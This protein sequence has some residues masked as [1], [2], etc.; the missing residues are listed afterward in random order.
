FYVGVALFILLSTPRPYLILTLAFGFACFGRILAFVF[1][2]VRS[3]QHVG[4][5]IGDAI[6]S[7]IPLI[8]VVGGFFFVE[9]I[10]GW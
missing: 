9:Q 1:D 2:R 5:I 10:L 4:A 3:L 7:A 8:H 6:L